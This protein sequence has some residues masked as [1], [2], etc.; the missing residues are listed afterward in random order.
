MLFSILFL[1][2]PNSKYYLQSEE[3]QLI[4]KIESEYSTSFDAVDIESEKWRIA[5]YPKSFETIPSEGKDL[6]RRLL[7]V[8]PRFRLKSVMALQRI[9]MYMKFDVKEKY[10]LEHSP[11]KIIED[12]GAFVSAFS[13]KDVDFEIF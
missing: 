5:F 11:R 6:L 1:Q 12:H 10:V 7:E 3:S 2:Y 9:S 4:E 8:N 13:K